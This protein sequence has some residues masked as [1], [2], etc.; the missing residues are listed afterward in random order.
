MT[1]SGI[2]RTGWCSRAGLLALS[3]LATIPT[4]PEQP[5]PAAELGAELVVVERDG[6]SMTTA[7]CVK[8]APEAGAGDEQTFLVGIVNGSFTG[9]LTGWTAS[10]S[11]GSASPG[12]VTPVAGQA[13]LLEGD[14]FLVTL[15]QTF[16]VPPGAGYLGFRLT[17]TPGFDRSDSFVPD[18]FEAQLLDA[19]TQTPVV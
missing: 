3:A 8:L 1:R 17:L 12:G 18:A 9:G 4:F 14:S 16:T 2:R 5:A 13:Q 11:G 6:R 10:Q 7:R 19:T 15:K